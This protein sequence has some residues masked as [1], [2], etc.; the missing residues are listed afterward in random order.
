MVLEHM[1]ENIGGNA[2]TLVILLSFFIVIYARLTKKTVKETLEQIKSFF[3]G[4][5]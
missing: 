4:E 3:G 1:G 2:L 5:D